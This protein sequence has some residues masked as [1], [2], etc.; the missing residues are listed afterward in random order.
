MSGAP[1]SASSPVDERADRQRTAISCMDAAQHKDDAYPTLEVLAHGRVDSPG[2]S[3]RMDNTYN[4]DPQ[5]PACPASAC[6]RNHVPLPC[7]MSDALL[8]KCAARN[9]KAGSAARGVLCRVPCGK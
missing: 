8:R 1:A 6:F 7:E 2:T 5:A 3:G 9:V 4:F